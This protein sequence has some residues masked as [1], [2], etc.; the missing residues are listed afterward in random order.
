MAEMFISVKQAGGVDAGAGSNLREATFPGR[1]FERTGSTTID[2]IQ[3]DSV[4]H[5]ADDCRAAFR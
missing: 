2:E 5:S 4:S 3:V 1:G